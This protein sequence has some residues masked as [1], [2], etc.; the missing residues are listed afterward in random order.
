MLRHVTVD[1]SESGEGLR[2]VDAVLRGGAQ[3]R[4]A[5]D[6][7]LVHL[8]VE[9]G[10]SQFVERLGVEPRVGRGSADLHQGGHLALLVAGEAVGD[11]LLVVGIDVVGPVE[12]VEHLAVGFS[13][14]LVVVAAE[15]AVGAAVHRVLP[16]QRVARPYVGVEPAGGGLVVLELEPAVAYVVRKQPALGPVVERR[17]VVE[18]G[19][20]RGCLGVAAAAVVGLREPVAR[21]LVEPVGLGEVVRGGPEIRLRVAVGAALEELPA[22]QEVGL[23]VVVLH[24]GAELVDVV[25][26]GYGGGVVTVGEGREGHVAVDL[27]PPR[28]GGIALEVV[29]EAGGVLVEVE[30]ELGVVERGVL[31]HPGVVVDCGRLAEGLHGGDL[32]AGSDVGVAQMV[33]GDLAQRVAAVGHPGVVLDGALPVVGGVQH[34]AGVEP[35]L[36]VHAA[37][38]GDLLV[39]FARAVHVAE[40]QI[41]LGDNPR[42]P[43]PALRGCVGVNADSLVDH[44]LV[45]L[46]VELAVDYVE[47][48]EIGEPGVG[49]GL[50]ELGLSLGEAAVV[51]VDHAGDIV[52]GSAELRMVEGVEYGEE[53]LSLGVAPHGERAVAALEDVFRHFGVGER[54]RRHLGE[55]QRG[56]AE[57]ALVEEYPGVLEPYP[58]GEDGGG[59]APVI[60]CHELPVVVGAHLESAEDHIA[61]GRRIGSEGLEHRPRPFIHAAPVEVQSQAPVLPAFGRDRLHSGRGQHESEQRKRCLSDSHINKL[62]PLIYKFTQFCAIFACLTQ[63]LLP[64]NGQQQLPC[65]LVFRSRY[66]ER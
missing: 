47:I 10:A 12:L 19:V 5:A 31:G 43:V 37:A 66:P 64:Q 57:A 6:R 54:R 48:G 41:G 50:E 45:V 61:F 32:V 15:V 14:G 21:V 51:V 44:V 30:G 25:V 24:V 56:F 13:R 60:F 40:N 23:G 58:A 7:L 55:L 2:H 38:V 11:C 27:L 22:A 9:L 4:E 29:C 35:V 20:G 36:A 39:V 46:A 1:Q 3:A 33:I 26:G 52:A 16:V 34:R 28:P 49:G 18:F 62:L 17:T 59:I 42:E 53:L 8:E 65:D 63:K